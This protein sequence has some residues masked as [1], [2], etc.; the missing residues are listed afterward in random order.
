MI[1]LFSARYFTNQAHIQ[2]EFVI[3]RV[4]GE[5]FFIRKNVFLLRPMTEFFLD[6]YD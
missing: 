6:F 4:V 1:L 2:P 5:M 3:V